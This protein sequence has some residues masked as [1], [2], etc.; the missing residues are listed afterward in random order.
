MFSELSLSLSDEEQMVRDTALAFFGEHA[1]VARLR[2]L[3]DRE[4]V[5]LYEPDVWKAAAEAGFA[6][7][8][9]SEADGGAGLGYVAAGLMHYAIGRNLSPVPALS[10]AVLSLTALTRCAAAARWS[11]HVAA[12]ARGDAIAALAVD[13]VPRHDPEH[14]AARTRAG[15]AGFVMTGR[16][17]FVLDGLGADLFIVAARLDD[18]G[19]IGLFLVPASAP[20]LEIAPVKT[21]DSRNTARVAL[22]EVAVPKSAMLSDGTDGLCDLVLDAGR[23]AL[24]AELVGI[25][26]SCFALTLDHLK[27]REQFGVR[28]GSFQALQHR[29]AHLYCQIE[30]ARSVSFAALRALDDGAGERSLLA[31]AAKAKAGAV[32]H[33]AANEAVQMHGGIGMTD[34][35][36]IGLYFKRARAAMETLGDTYFHA[37]RV[38]R[39]LNY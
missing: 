11:A 38:A 29:M 1:D 26:E 36:D 21:I 8:I 18:Q 32:A 20:G 35:H 7:C 6:G 4:D 13:E 24:S 37:N 23:A 5:R 10:S 34:E 30:L 27:Q 9:A 31:S 39:L 28:I 22:H 16:K 3:R 33:L 2:R 14:I 12:I 25:A 15:D 17:V 19:P